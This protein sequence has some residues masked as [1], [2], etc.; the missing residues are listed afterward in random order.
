MS[1]GSRRRPDPGY[2]RAAISWPSKKSRR[3]PSMGQG[4]H[5]PRPRGISGRAPRHRRFQPP[6]RGEDFGLDCRGPPSIRARSSASRHKAY[7]PVAN[8]RI[9]ETAVIQILPQRLAGFRLVCGRARNYVALVRIPAKAAVE[10]GLVYSARQGAGADPHPMRSKA[11]VPRSCAIQQ[12][13]VTAP[14]AGANAPAPAVWAG[15]AGRASARQKKPIFSNQCHGTQPAKPVGRLAQLPRSGY[16]HPAPRGR[17]PT[18][19]ASA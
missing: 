6:D 13:R 17:F 10:E 12:V 9:S 14:A 4:R 1:R 11:R 19:A 15:L 2:R 16:L 18:S 8:S 3:R 7:A 5:R